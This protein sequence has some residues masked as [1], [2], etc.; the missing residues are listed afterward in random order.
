MRRRSQR[1]VVMED[2]QVAAALSAE[3]AQ[4]LGPQRFELWFNTQAQLCVEASCLTIRAA[5][6]FVLEWL[7]KNLADDIRACWEGI[8]G[9]GC[10]VEY[11]IAE[12]QGCSDVTA[13]AEA[14]ETTAKKSK[15]GIVAAQRAAK[16]QTPKVEL[17][18]TSVNVELSAF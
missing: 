4:R 15:E 3:L 7:R 17:P 13:A 18:G 12:A 2:S 9:T 6:S 10:T 11:N 5:S 14:V 8:A 16:Q 1:E